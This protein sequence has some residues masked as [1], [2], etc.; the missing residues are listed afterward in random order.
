MTSPIIRN[1]AC[2]ANSRAMW[3]K[4]LSWSS[5]V[6]DDHTNKMRY[7]WL[8]GETDEIAGRLVGN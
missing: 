8:S 1:V 7:S 4:M 2:A 5:L 3:M 6:L